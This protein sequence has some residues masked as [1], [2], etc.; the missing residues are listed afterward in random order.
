MLSC[1]RVL[2]LLSLATAC[3][4]REKAPF[5]NTRAELLCI[6]DDARQHDSL[7]RFYRRL[8]FTTLRDVGPG[9]GSVADRV[10]WGGE[11]TIMSIDIDGLRRSRYGAAVRE[12]GR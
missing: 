7:L 1:Q 4:L 12:L 9:L 5:G 11:G 6:R 10:V 8:G 3:F 2:L